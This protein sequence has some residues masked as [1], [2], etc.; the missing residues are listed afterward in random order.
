MALTVPPPTNSYS[1]PDP[2]GWLF[3]HNNS[4]ENSLYQDDDL[5]EFSDDNNNNNDND[6]SGDY[7]QKT[8]PYQSQTHH[9]EVSI[10][11][12]HVF[13]YVLCKFFSYLKKKSSYI[14]K[15]MLS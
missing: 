8:P 1:Q 2:F 12:N 13:H 15:K 11:Q 10:N 14:Q 7:Q 5:M 6:N 9:Q 4:Q 3:S